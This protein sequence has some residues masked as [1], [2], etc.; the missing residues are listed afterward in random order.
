MIPPIGVKIFG[1][2][3]LGHKLK[4]LQKQLNQFGAS[5]TKIGRT[6]SVGMTVPMGMFGIHTLKTAA[7]FEYG[8]NRVAAITEATGK[9]FALLRGEAKRLGEETTFTAGQVTQGMQL[10]AQASLPVQDIFKGVG[11][12]LEGAQ[13]NMI[14]MG[15]AANISVG[16]MKTFG[17]TADELRVVMDMLTKT[18]MSS[19]TNFTQLA[20]AFIYAGPTAGAMGKTLKETS[21]ILG[22]LANGMIKSSMAG[23]SLRGMMAKLT[24]PAPQAISIM[25]GL[26]LRYKD[27]LDTKGNLHSFIDIVKAFEKTSITA[28]QVLQIFGLRAG[29]G[30]QVLLNQGS[31]ALQKMNDTIGD[32]AGT[33]KRI[34][35]VQIRGFRG[36]LWMLRSAFEGFEIAIADSGIL[37]FATKIAKKF[38]E[39][40]RVFAKFHPGILKV[41]FGLLMLTA[42][43]GPLLIA[44]GAVSI[45]IAAISWPIIGI[46]AG[47][48]ALGVGIAALIIWWDRIVEIVAK[49][50][51]MLGLIAG[52][53]GW[54]IWGVGLLIYN[55][56][57][58]SQ[59]L[60]DVYGWLKKVFDAIS[61]ANLMKLAELFGFGGG[62]EEEQAAK[63][64]RQEEMGKMFMGG[65]GYIP[66]SRAQIN[67]N[68]PNA[69]KGTDVTV[70]SEEIEMSVEQGLAFQG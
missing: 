38:T 25:K 23:T 58:F 8:M 37:Q 55:W 27:I 16:L 67:V 3:A 15:E 28:G 42:V 53:I 62:T 70:E 5:A 11:A 32:F 66:T 10:M 46:I 4:R 29:P 40:F 6:M 19:M 63:L 49:F 30:F 59:T 64:A 44:L 21:T 48:V 9:D 24:A 54:L 20:D 33:T 17:Y 39:L 69:P 31:E 13:A 50:G 47:V 36:Q 57:E 51:W 18:S 34:S 56:D 1:K 14:D 43:I 26:G 45:A 60:K 12:V 65:A 7:D 2:D 22:S 61:N 68:I 41:G 52:P 35:D